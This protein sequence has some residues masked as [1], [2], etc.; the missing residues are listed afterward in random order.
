RKAGRARA[1]PTCGSTTGD[2]AARGRRAL[3]WGSLRTSLRR[4]L[5]EKWAQI[6]AQDP[7]TGIADCA[8][9][10]SGHATA[11]PPSSVM[12]SR[13][14]LIQLPR[15]E[16]RRRD[17]EAERLGSL[18]VDG[19]FELRRL[20]YRKIGRLCPI[21][22]LENKRGR[23]PSQIRNTRSIRDKPTISDRLP[24]FIHCWKPVHRN[25][26]AYLPP[27]RKKTVRRTGGSWHR[28]R[29]VS[30][31]RTL[32]GACRGPKRRT[33]EIAIQVQDQPAG[34]H[35]IGSDAMDFRR[36]RV[37]QF[38]GFRPPPP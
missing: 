29:P 34:G 14:L 22:H 16:Q 37:L 23:T 27:G 31:W 18:E 24:R 32:P 17:F 38:A 15:C 20:L 5:L 36:C 21:D 11:A 10:A 19:Q 4:V 8:L 26:A 9:A 12:N 2:H 7:I 28:S 33:D 30:W 25:E 13:R 6:G 35:P 1:G 3:T